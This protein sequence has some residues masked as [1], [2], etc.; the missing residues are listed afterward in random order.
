MSFNQ[1]F[2]YNAEISCNSLFHRLNKSLFYNNSTVKQ[3]SCVVKLKR[4]ATSVVMQKRILK[5][6]NRLTNID[7]DLRDESSLQRDQKRTK[8]ISSKNQKFV[9]KWNVKWKTRKC[10][11]WPYLNEFLT[12]WNC[13]LITSVT[14][15]HDIRFHNFFSNNLFIF[16][17]SRSTIVVVT[18]FH[19][20]K[21]RLNYQ[22]SSFIKQKTEEL[23]RTMKK[24]KSSI[25]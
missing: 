8:Q 2:Y 1:S 18:Q 13:Q 3:S 16:P 6:S 19:G 20:I 24:R 4:N 25:T 15:L 14:N 7:D 10:F 5:R 22:R 21:T 12:N 23:N 9:A 11:C 17:S